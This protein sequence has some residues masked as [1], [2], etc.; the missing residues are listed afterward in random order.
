M[1]RFSTMSIRP[2]PCLRAS[3]L[4][5]RKRGVGEVEVPVV[6]EVNLFGIPE[7]NS[8]VMSSGSL[9]AERMGSAVSFHCDMSA[10][11]DE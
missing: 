1:K 6:E 9:G 4:A 3:W 7:A 8:M 2:M 11:V 10:L 5:A